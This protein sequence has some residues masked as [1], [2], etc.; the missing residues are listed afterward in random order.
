MHADTHPSAVVYQTSR[1]DETDSVYCPVCGTTWDIFEVAAFDTGKSTQADFPF[2]KRHVC[3]ILGET[4]Q[5]PIRQPSVTPKPKTEAVPLSIVDA[6]TVYTK[7]KVQSLCDLMNSG[8]GVGKIVKT[9]PYKDEQGRVILADVRL[10]DETGKK[11]VISIYYNGRNLVSKGYPIAVYNRDKIST[12]KPVIIHE[13][14]KAADTAQQSLP[15]FTHIA[16]NGGAKKVNQVDWSFLSQSIVYLIP[17]DDAKRE[18]DNTIKPIEQQPGYAA[19]LYIYNQIKHIAAAKIVP[20]YIPAR[21][22]KDDGADIVEWLQAGTPEQIEAHILNSAN[23]AP[24]EQIAGEEKKE[25]IFPFRILGVADDGKAYFVDESG[26]LQSSPLDKITR[27]KMLTLAPL[28]FW[29]TYFG[30]DGKMKQDQWDDANDAIIRLANTIDFDPDNLRGRGAWREK[31]GR[32]CYHDGIETIGEHADDK[33]FLRKIKNDIGIKAPHTSSEIIG[34][35]KEV[36]ELMTFETKADA[37]RCLAWAILSPFSGALP[38]RPAGLLT[39]DSSSGKTAILNYLIR[40]IGEPLVVTAQESSVAGIRQKINNDSCGIA[41]EEAE[42]GTEAKNKKRDEFFSLMRVSFSDDAPD[43]YKGTQDQA[44]KSFKMKNMFLFISISSEVEEVA[45]DK[46][47]FRINLVPKKNDW[48]AVKSSLTSL[49][50]DDNCK[51]IRALTWSKLNDIITMSEQVSPLIAES[52]GLDTRSSMSEAMLYCAHRIIWRSLPVFDE[53]SIRADIK[54]IFAL[55]PVEESRNEVEEMLDRLLDEV[56]MIP[57]TGGEKLS[58][59]KIL[60]CIKSGMIEDDTETQSHGLSFRPMK[61]VEEKN[62]K[63][64]VESYGI[65]YSP[66]YD[67]VAVANNHHMVKKILNRGSGYYRMLWRHPGFR[68]DID[69]AKSHSVYLGGKTRRCVLIQGLI[70]DHTDDSVPF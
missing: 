22:L 32:I 11:S 49:L 70:K 50:T 27:G 21:K 56:V 26:R 64:I 43:A 69:E 24:L 4:M 54:Q 42:A 46:R 13:G 23:N 30:E 59:R 55:Q 35:I 28:Q 44:G 48:P 38:N 2:I 15:I 66:T 62:F 40:P 45:D 7:E 52:T 6:K 31:D 60:S 37:M 61:K 29:R 3:D 16:W 34:K 41:L 14:A 68:P 67:A 18:R 65:T 63:R 1:G 5:E 47:I 33:L 19:M 39:G 58:L 8:K 25:S 51:G 17:D 53:Q 36:A 9:W 10:E 57:G 12:G 20:P